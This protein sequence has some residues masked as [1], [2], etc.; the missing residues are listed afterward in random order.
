MP[1][2]TRR[3]AKGGGNAGV[4]SRQV[5]KMPADLYSPRP[6]FPNKGGVDLSSVQA[7][8]ELTPLQR[9]TQVEDLKQLYQSKEIALDKEITLPIVGSLSAPSIPGLP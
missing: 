2:R 1:V 8:A 4:Q 6:A 7:G 3:S 5:L 9:S